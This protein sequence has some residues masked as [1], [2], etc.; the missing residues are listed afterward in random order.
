[1][2]VKK[3]KEPGDLKEYDQRRAGVPGGGDWFYKKIQAKAYVDQ[4]HG[5]GRGFVG[6]WPNTGNGYCYGVYAS[7]DDYLTNILKLAVGKRYGFEMIRSENRCNL[8]FDLEGILQN[9]RG[10][11]Y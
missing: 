2:P 5:P 4:K 3:N 11:G 10:G 9:G 1:M 7:Y 6:A 8:Y